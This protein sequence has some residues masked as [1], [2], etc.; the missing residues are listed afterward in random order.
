MLEG[1]HRGLR[2]VAALLA[3]SAL[4]ACANNPLAMIDGPFIP[5]LERAAA[6]AAAAA[7]QQASAAPEAAPVIAAA[8]PVQV[9]APA[10]RPVAP[11]PIERPLAEQVPPEDLAYPDQAFVGPVLTA[12]EMAALTASTDAAP[13]GDL[14]DAVDADFLPPQH[15][16]LPAPPVRTVAAAP[17]ASGLVGP[18]SGPAEPPVE[19]ATR[20]PSAFDFAPEPPPRVSAPRPDGAAAPMAS[21]FAAF[22]NFAVA[23]LAAPAPRGGRESMLLADP[24]SLDPALVT[25]ANRPPA[26]LLDLDPANALAPLVEGGATPNSIELGSYLAD[27]RQRGVTVYWITGHG[28]DAAS[29]IRRRLVAS[30]LD[31]TGRDPLI[32]TRFA[33]ESKQARRRALGETHCLLAIAGDQRADFDELYDFLL[34]P[35]AAA[36]LERHVDNGWFLTPPP[37][38]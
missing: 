23:R 14:P 20:L 24:P 15:E 18:A 16:P 32:V 26:V 27:L 11:A 8:E 7:E 3:A 29:A 36:Q 35:A 19:L 38:D 17:S 21:G 12:P 30:G 2:L 4:Q 37:L 10:P 1:G 9:A 33:G 6:A 28:P 13:A 25:C 34:D 31:S 22:H 5:A